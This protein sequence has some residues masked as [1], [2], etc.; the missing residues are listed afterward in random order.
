MFKISIESYVSECSYIMDKWEW[1]SKMYWK[2][3]F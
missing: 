2:R 3:A 1:E